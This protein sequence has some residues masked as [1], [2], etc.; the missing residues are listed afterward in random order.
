MLKKLFSAYGS[1]KK[2]LKLLTFR[3]FCQFSKDFALFLG[4]KLDETRLQ[5][6]FIKKVR[7]PGANFREFV[8]ILYTLAKIREDLA[9]TSQNPR[10]FEKIKGFKGFLDAIIV[11]KY[12]IFAQRLSEHNI[13]EIQVFYKDYN[14]YENPSLQLLYENEELFKHVREFYRIF[15]L[16]SRIFQDFLAVPALRHQ[17]S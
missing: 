6:L 14:P 17:C 1:E 10:N 9:K 8:D 3:K 11:P 12:K 16:I 7:Q 4:S 2:G 5:L 15:L 13:E